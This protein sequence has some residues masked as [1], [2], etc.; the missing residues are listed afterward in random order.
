MEETRQAVTGLVNE[1][2][3]P[4][5]DVR[6]N[7]APNERRVRMDDEPEPR[8]EEQQRRE[9]ETRTAGCTSAPIPVGFLIFSRF[10]ISLSGLA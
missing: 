5:A 6:R 4:A 7:E 8:R 1:Q 3:R 2:L 10:S 9:E